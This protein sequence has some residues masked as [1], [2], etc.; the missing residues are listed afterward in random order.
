MTVIVTDA[1]DSSGQDRL[2][3]AGHSIEVVPAGDRAALIDALPGASGLV[4]GADQTVDAD[5]ID[6]SD[7]LAVI[8]VLGV[9]V[10]NVDVE[11][12]TDRGVL[13]T[14][15]PRA[16]VRAVA[17]F[18]VGMTFATARKIPQGHRRL[19]GGEW[20]KG[21]IIGHEL[22]GK[23]LGVLGLDEVGQE[24]ASRLAGLDM[25]VIAFDP[26]AD[27][28]Q[29][30][31]IGA[32]LV[33]DLAT[34]LETADILSVHEGRG[35]I[36]AL[37]ADDFDALAGGYLVDVTG[38][39]AIDEP[40]LA[41]AVDDGVLEG[42]ALD[43]FETTPL[44]ADSPLREVEN[45]ITTPELATEARPAPTGAARRIAE[46]VVDALA[47]ERVPQALNTPSI[48]EDRYPT[49]EPYADLAETAGRIAVQLLAESAD[50]ITISFAGPVADEE[51]DIAAVAGLT[52]AL[53]ALGYDA[54]DANAH[55]VAADAGVDVSVET[56]SE[57]QDFRNLV[58]VTATADDESA[59]VSGT[60]F[61]DGES[62]IVRIADYRVEIVPYGTM[63]LVH[64]DDA[65]GV[66]GT[67][68]TI[69]GEHEVNIA[70]MFNSRETVG[71]DSLT[72]YNLDERPSDDL[73]SEI[74]ADDRVEDLDLV[75]LDL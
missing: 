35:E 70:G 33:D 59:S 50:G 61:A 13:V 66:I 15:A 62:R 52:G 44:P 39:A 8:G 74:L 36:P 12:A 29:A 69:L 47:G 42:A 49:V 45:V 25:D 2:R 32:T 16:S 65:P 67:I 37:D 31:R 68:G 20:A 71:G 17:E 21:P 63:M 53:D 5:V 26:G 7:A 51:I 24:I 1:L 56:A 10:T 3:D 40:A 60:Q 75:S 73:V 30:R 41:D 46:T 54:T 55:A 6:A 38:G 64:N 34:V 72:V 23:T 22:D 43:A 28:D 9:D 58:T 57:A 18:A 27:D 48:P 11:A 4:V 19:R 14:T